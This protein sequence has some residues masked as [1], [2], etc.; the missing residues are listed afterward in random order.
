MVMTF[1]LHPL[2]HYNTI[3][4]SRAW[5]LLSL[6]EGLTIDFHS[7]FILSLIDVFRDTMTRDKLIFP[8]AI[9]RLL[10]YFSISYPESPHFMF[11]CA[12][13]AATVKQSVDELR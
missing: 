6:I 2:S 12:I 5:F 7:H 10:C 11:M 4:E 13:D 8:F 9:T 3:T 1:V